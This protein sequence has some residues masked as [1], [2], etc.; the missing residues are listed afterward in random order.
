[1]RE[2]LGDY[3]NPNENR[4]NF[5]LMNRDYDDDLIEHIVASCKSLEVLKYVEFTG[6][7]YIDDEKE[8]D[9]NHYI[10]TRRKTKK[11]SDIKYMYLQDSRYAELRLKFRLNCKGE[12]ANI[13]KKLLI[14]VPDENGYYTIKGK[15]YFLLYQ[16]VDAST[17]TTRQNLTLKSLMPVSIKRNVK[18]FK[19][20]TGVLH[21]APAYMIMIFKKPVDILLFYFAKIGVKKTLEYFEVN[22]TMRFVSEERDKDNNI[23]FPIS[24]KIML[25]VNK[26]FFSKYSYVQSLAFMILSIVTNRLSF[27]LLEDRT[28]WIERIGSL[29]ATNAYNYYEKGLNTLTFFDRMLDETTKKIL[30]LHEPN[31]KNMYSVVRWMIQNYNELRKKDNLDLTNKRLRCNEYI[32][33]L[34]TKE[35][36]QRVN[37]IIALGNKVTIDKV[38]EIFKFPGMVLMEQ[39]YKSGLLRF[40]DKIND[41]DFYSKY[42][43]TLKG[44]NA[45][46]GKNDNNISVKYRGIHPSYIGL[47]DINVCGTSDPGSSG[48]ITPFAKTDGLYFDNSFEPEDSVFEMQREAMEYYKN[49]NKDK[50]IVDVYAGCN[51]IS[52]MFNMEAKMRNV[53]TGMTLHQREIEDTSKMYVRLNMNG[54]DDWI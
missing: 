42:R 21:T 28:Y 23:Y 48:V 32:A 25:E 41:M 13:E 30:K 49:D 6:Y 10:T 33:S 35:F 3:L 19:D 8:I 5:G 34:L 16:L 51:N 39:L 31:K 1:M 11:K 50:M 40:D 52:D 44:P 47:I 18:E 36:S 29:N 14:P 46:G 38:K 20:T 27:D 37:R 53:M 9:L 12:K 24:S 17:Y 54:D 26:Y 45:L 2:F 4:L 22:T 7:D 43:F 15:K